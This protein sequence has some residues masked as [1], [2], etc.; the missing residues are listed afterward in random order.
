MRFIEEKTQ[1][2]QLK[3]GIQTLKTNETR[4]YRQQLKAFNMNR[5]SYEKKFLKHHPSNT[6]L[7]YQGIL[8]YTKVYLCDLLI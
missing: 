6:L 3:L 5:R 1:A 2:F 7:V 8:R 4:H